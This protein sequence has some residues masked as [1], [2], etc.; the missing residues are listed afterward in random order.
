MVLSMRNGSLLRGLAGVVALACCGWAGGQVMPPMSQTAPVGAAVPQ[1]LADR[2]PAQQAAKRARVQFSGGQLVVMAENSS[3]N[4]ILREISRVT[5]MKISGGVTDERV[6]GN[7]GPADAGTVLS[8]LLSGTG[9]NMMMIES[10]ASRPQELV[11]TP[12]QGGVTPPSPNASRDAEP[13]EV[14]DL[15]P[16]QTPR[17]SRPPAVFPHAPVVPGPV[18]PPPVQPAAQPAPPVP[19]TTTQQS[20]NGVLTPQDV[21]DQLVKALQQKPKPPAPQ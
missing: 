20:P 10:T 4:Q 7:Y 16:Q 6:F 13:E 18:P 9:S 15:P 1:A 8:A 2:T 14:Q 21:Y 5:G 17:V 12:R 3:L 11:L 19:G